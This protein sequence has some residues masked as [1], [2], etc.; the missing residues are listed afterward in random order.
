MSK[1]DDE[2]NHIIAEIVREMLADN[3][4]DPKTIPKRYIPKIQAVLKAAK[5]DAIA[6]G[7]L[8]VVKRLQAILATL[9]DTGITYNVH[10]NSLLEPKNK[11]KTLHPASQLSIKHTPRYISKESKPNVESKIARPRF[12]RPKTALQYRNKRSN[13]KPS[14]KNNSDNDD[15]ASVDFEADNN[16]YKINN[17]NYSSAPTEK[18]QT[19]PKPRPKKRNFIDEQLDTALENMVSGHS[20]IPETDVLPELIDYAKR[21]IDSLIESG[22]LIGAQKYEDVYQQ[23]QSSKLAWEECNAKSAKLVELTIHMNKTD[24]NLRN[25]EERMQEELSNYDDR[26]EAIREAQIQ[27]FE[28]KLEDF[29]NETNFRVIERNEDDSFQSQSNQSTARNSQN[30][31]Y[32][33]NSIDQSN[34]ENS[35]DSQNS[36]NQSNTENSK[37]SQNSNCQQLNRTGSSFRSTSSSNKPKIYP[38]LPPSYRK[39]SQRLLDLRNKEKLLLK[40]R[41][42][43]EAGYARIEAD[44]IEAY[45]IVQCKN[46]YLKSRED[47][48][49]KMIEDHNQK[50]KCFEENIARTRKRLQNE[51]ETKITAL[52]R[53][54]ENFQSRIDRLNGEIKDALSITPAPSP[55]QTRPL[56]PNRSPDQ[57]QSTTFMTQNQQTFQKNQKIDNDTDQKMK[58]KRAISSMASPQVVYRPIPSKWRLQ[59]PMILKVHK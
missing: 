38:N 24:K 7:Q 52:K 1:D 35:K 33:D 3:Q 59:T 46:N 51:N 9:P 53:A 31:Q 11:R 43:E 18:L 32:S 4:Y 44:N 39:F 29:D 22:E 28:D 34:S 17:Q 47:K 21:K 13:T 49:A 10:T 48:R 40:T 26:M 37:V 27:E 55:L 42:F 23:M 25:A 58:K 54:K 56:S 12:Y 15:L 16:N 36:M 30:T 20:F 57:F 6:R 14:S 5:Q 50:M 41:R 8:P 2:E 19:N 45:E